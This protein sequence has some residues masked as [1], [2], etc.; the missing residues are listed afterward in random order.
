MNRIQDFFLNIG[1]DKGVDDA[2]F[3]NAYLTSRI[4]MTKSRTF[5]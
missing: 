2:N 4:F 1:W 3:S 5:I